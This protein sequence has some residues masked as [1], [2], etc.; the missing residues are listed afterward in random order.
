[1]RNRIGLML[2]VAMVLGFSSVN[3]QSFTATLTG[4]AEVPGPGDP[5]GTGTASVTLTGL[6]VNYNINVANVTLAPV[7]QH[8]HTGAAGV[9]GGVVINLPGTWVGGNLVG[10]TTTDVATANALVANPQLFYVNVH[11]ADFGA[12][13]VRGQLA[14]VAAAPVPTLSEW[15]LY[16]LAGTLALAGAFLL[17]R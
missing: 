8:I 15:V 14:A 9:A 6:T 4:A 3:A 5:D 17:K 1:M 10:S 12:G 13:A 2:L 16:G 11:T 7:A